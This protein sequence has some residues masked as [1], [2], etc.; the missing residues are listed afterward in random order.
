MKKIKLTVV[1]CVLFGSV[2]SA[3]ESGYKKNDL[4]LNLGIGVNSSY[5]GGIPLSVSLETGSTDQISV[6]VSFDYLS[7]KYSAGALSS[8][9]FTALYFGA[10]ASYHVNELLNL[11]SEKI[12]LY[13]GITV[14]YRSFKWKDS[15]SNNTLSDRYGSGIFFGGHIGGKYYFTQTIGAF[16]EVGATGSTN[17]R[18]GLAFKL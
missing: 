5:Y 13:G 9:K 18:L 12:D 14:G 15:Y 11:N 10:R 3:Q 1:L 8:Y 16:T 4:L 6:G 2:S 7:D 17:M